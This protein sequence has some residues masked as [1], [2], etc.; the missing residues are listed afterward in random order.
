MLQ[1]ESVKHIISK[2]TFVKGC[3]CTKAFWL[4][5]F[6][7]DLKQQVST[8]QQ[9]IFDQGS[10]VG[11]LAR[12]LFP[13]GTDVSPATPFD[14]AKSIAETYAAI[15]D[16]K[17]IIYESAFQ[18]NRVLAALDILVSE[19]DGWVAYEVKSSTGVKETFILDAAL[20]YYLITNAGVPLKD[21]ALITI[22]NQ[23]IR[24]GTL[25]INQLFTKTSILSE[26]K[27]LQQNV[28]D[29]ITEL[30]TISSLKTE[31]VVEIGRQCFS[32]YECDFK[33][34]CW[35]HLPSD[36]VFDL[37]GRGAM[38]IAF[39]LYQQG[40]FTFQNMPTGLTLSERQ[41]LQVRA[42]LG[43]SDSISIDDI[44][45]F[46]NTLRYPIYYLDFETFQNAVPVFDNQ[47]P[48]QQIPF[49]YS[50][51]V[52]TS[53]DSTVDHFSFLANTPLDC[54]REFIESLLGNIGEDGTVLVYNIG[55]EKSILNS[56]ALLFP[57]HDAAIRLVISRLIDLMEPFRAGYYYKPQ[58]K[59]SY[60][61]KDV[62]PAL[63]PEL[64]YDSLEIK[65]GGYA[66]Q[67][68]LNLKN[69]T[70]EHEIASVRA[71]LLEYCKLDTFAM[72]KVLEK[73]FECCNS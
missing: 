1:P 16:G 14:Y 60:S 27:A 25:D 29:K 22:N 28:H 37:R 51:H 11:L 70:D 61:I 9:A 31:P 58:M 71:N 30:A 23:Y 10:N 59:G 54:R 17:T 33:N 73:L 50:L 7:R 3:Q 15:N 24:Q 40:V 20:Q 4:N 53:P 18:F 42:H 12:E 56:M 36:S 2:S 43:N 8:S 39:G 63:V 6:R 32:P 55:F 62:L 72:I 19:N 44:R 49:Q 45:E 65:D 41:L 48:Y 52:Q 5:K 64:S 13:G 66:S 69:M 26:V 57:E 21:I 46:L 38:D 34:Y 67:A 35:G 68:F 47:K